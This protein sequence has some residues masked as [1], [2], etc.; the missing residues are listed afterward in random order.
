MAHFGQGVTVGA[1]GNEGAVARQTAMCLCWL[2]VEGAARGRFQSL[3]LCGPVK[4]L[5]K[6]PAAQL[7][8]GETQEVAAE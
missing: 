3:M 7:P 4:S 8:P 5:P 2:R 1:P 6:L